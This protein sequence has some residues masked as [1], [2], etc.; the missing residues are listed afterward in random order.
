ME[1]VFITGSFH[2]AVCPSP[3]QPPAGTGGISQTQPC[4]DLESETAPC[5][6]VYSAVSPPDGIKN[7]S[8]CPKQ[9]TRS[10]WPIPQ[11]PCVPLIQVSLSVRLLV[12]GLPA[13]S[14][15]TCPQVPSSLSL[16]TY[17]PVSMSCFNSLTI[18]SLW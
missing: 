7:E 14:W 11:A 13:D 3:N 8:C 4:L 15:S 2:P 1:S 5:S 17:T 16:T 18:R 10:V 12:P 9:G 6:R